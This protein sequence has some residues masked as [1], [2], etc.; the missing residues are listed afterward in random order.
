MSDS[1]K[2][3]IG[4][5]GKI[6][7]LTLL[8]GVELSLSTWI[9]LSSERQVLIFLIAVAVINRYAI[10][11]TW[12]YGRRFEMQ[13]MGWCSTF[14]MV[15]LILFKASA[16]F[17]SIFWFSGKGDGLFMFLAYASIIATLTE[18]LFPKHLDSTS[19]NV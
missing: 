5:I 16:E 15:V 3:Q 18:I 4:T 17:G 1:P 7:L 2:A 9:E 19:K 12:N 8:V 10:Q 13:L 14:I 6:L 11:K